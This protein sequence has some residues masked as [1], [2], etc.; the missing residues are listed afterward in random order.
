MIMWRIVI[1]L[2]LLFITIEIAHAETE[3]KPNEVQQAVIELN[4]L[5]FK[6]KDVLED[7]ILTRAIADV[8]PVDDFKF[9]FE[10]EGV[11]IK[12]TF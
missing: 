7:N 2:L 6:I 12:W 9:V 5:T 8:M 1:I 11:I 4:N 10:I 3:S